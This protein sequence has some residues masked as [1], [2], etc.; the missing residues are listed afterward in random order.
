MPV[1]SEHINDPRLYRELERQIAL[2]LT[3]L[4]KYKAIFNDAPLGIFRA[5]IGGK[6]IE[7][8]NTFS[9]LLGYGSPEEL[10]RSVKDIA[11]Q[12]YANARERKKLIAEILK[13]TAVVRHETHFKRLNGSLF[14]VSITLKMVYNEK[15][16]PLYLSGIVEDIT[17]RKKVQNNLIN[18]R[19]QLRILIDNIPDYIYLKDNKDEFI[20]VNKA[21]AGLLKIKNPDDLTGKSIPTI[22]DKFV[23]NLLRD[24]KEIL[25]HGRPLLNKEESGKNSEGK[26]IHTYTSK[27]PLKDNNKNVQ[28][29]IGIGRDITELKLAQ[30]QISASQANLNAVLE[31]TKNAIWSLNREFNLITANIHFNPVF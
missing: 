2:Y 5:T 3:D 11:K 26:V 12:I 9:S 28:G 15:G 31:S 13:G 4:E 16:K 30:Q 10:I 6:Y 20:I 7:V 18:E 27:I 14:P 8:N 29:L 23:A 25:K 22:T 24:D 21:F 1:T 17:I 19:N